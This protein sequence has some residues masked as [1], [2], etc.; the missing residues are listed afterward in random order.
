MDCAE[1]EDMEA[2][3]VGGSVAVMDEESD[4][5]STMAA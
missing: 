3:S 2:D 1:Q 5:D 4:S